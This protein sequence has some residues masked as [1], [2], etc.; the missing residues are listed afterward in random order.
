MG[1]FMAKQTKTKT[2]SQQIDL[3]NFLKDYFFVSTGRPYTIN[4]ILECLR[5]HN[6]SP[7]T[8]E[9]TNTLMKLISNGEIRIG[10]FPTLNKCVP[11]YDRR[12]KIFSKIRLLIHILCQ[13]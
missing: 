13:Q 11:W 8:D 10:V 7:Q 1:G 12:N 2:V 3:Y 5:R 4:D 6:I 9:L